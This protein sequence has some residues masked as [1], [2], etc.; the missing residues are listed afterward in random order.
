MKVNNHLDLVMTTS[1]S[2]WKRTFS[3]ITRAS[4]W[5]RRKQVINKFIVYLQKDNE[6]L[7]TKRMKPFIKYLLQTL[8]YFKYGFYTHFL[9]TRSISIFLSPSLSFYGSL[10]SLALNLLAISIKGMSSSSEDPSI[11]GDTYLQSYVM[12]VCYLI[13]S[14]QSCHLNLWGW[15]HI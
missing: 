8:K 14:L 1:F 13:L 15:W 3:F 11:Y 10:D 6:I 12:E 5:P 7:H 9:C 2:L 4:V